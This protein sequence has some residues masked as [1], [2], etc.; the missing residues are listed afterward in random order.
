[1]TD[2]TPQ[3]QP[4]MRSEPKGMNKNGV[5]VLVLAI[6]AFVLGIVAKGM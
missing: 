6:L 3:P 2:Y 5:T 4:P 1:M